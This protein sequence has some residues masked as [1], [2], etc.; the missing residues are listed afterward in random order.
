MYEMFNYADGLWNYQ[1]DEFLDR[2]SKCCLQLERI[3]LII[4]ETTSPNVT[5]FGPRIFSKDSG[6]WKLTS[7]DSS[8]NWILEGIPWYLG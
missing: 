2:I 7:C 8:E 6:V 3:R 4:V 1:I 5:G